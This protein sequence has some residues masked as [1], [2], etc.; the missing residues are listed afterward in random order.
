MHSQELWSVT[1]PSLTKPTFTDHRSD[2]NQLDRTASAV[3]SKNTAKAVAIGDLKCLAQN[4][5]FEA[6]GEPVEGKL[7]VAHV[8][9]NWVASPRFPNT[10]CGVVH[11]GGHA[12]RNRCQF[13]W[14]CDG[15]SET[16]TNRRAW[17]ESLKLA[18]SVYRDRSIDPTDNALWYHADYVSPSWRYGLAEGPKIGHHI[19]YRDRTSVASLV[20]TASSEN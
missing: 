15:K 17:L 5:Y 4:I 9:M 1:N 6:R 16:I 20:Q 13:S 19:F 12:V 8:V 2:P 14:W 10:V 18:H 11:Q 3:F 7:A